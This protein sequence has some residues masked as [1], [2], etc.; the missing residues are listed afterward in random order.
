MY[1]DWIGQLGLQYAFHH[2]TNLFHHA[3][4]HLIG[5]GTLDSQSTGGYNYSELV[6][7]I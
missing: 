5:T 7:N 4:S 2:T 1:E 3:T 6:E